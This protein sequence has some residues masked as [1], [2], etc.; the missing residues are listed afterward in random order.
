M[1]LSHARHQ[2]L[3]KYLESKLKKSG[4]LVLLPAI[5][6]RFE[7]L[8]LADPT[9]TG[10]YCKWILE[11][12]LKKDIALPEDTQKLQE[13]LTVYHRVKRRLPLEFREI[14]RFNTYSQLRITLLPMLPTLRSN[15]ELIREGSE[16]IATIPIKDVLY[17]LFKLTTPEAAS[18][19]AKNTGW[20]ICNL[21]TAADYL[22]RSPLYLITRNDKPYCLAHRD[23]HQV[24]D[25]NDQPFFPGTENQ[26]YQAILQIFRQYLPEFLCQKPRKDAPLFPHLQIVNLECSSHRCQ[27]IGCPE[28][29]FKQC[30]FKDCDD[31]F[32]PKH[33]ETCADCDLSFCDSHSYECASKGCS[34][35]HCG[36]DRQTCR[37]CD[38]TICGECSHHCEECDTLYCDEC[39]FECAGSNCDTICRDCANSSECEE[40][41]GDYCAKCQEKGMVCYNCNA[42]ICEDCLQQHCDACAGYLCPRCK[43]ECPSCK[44][45]FCHDCSWYCRKHCDETY[46]EECYRRICDVCSKHSK[47]EL[48][49][50]SIC[51]K[52][53]ICPQCVWKCS[54][55]GENI[56]GME[57]QKCN[58]PEEHILCS[59][60][61]QTQ[62]CNCGFVVCNPE[63][64]YYCAYQRS[65][66]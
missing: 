23:S 46:C 25:Q 60:C 15:A 58:C 7:Y 18:E 3:K 34:N 48:V 12:F 33:W 43:I 50:C 56:C 59:A 21:S 64:H 20:C 2:W 26:D 11:L 61:V 36:Q 30:E 44:G 9:L 52:E 63:D 6:D 17:Q 37:R 39:T 5:L 66:R 62:R 19:A 47:D 57:S 49:E 24:M 10:D 53:E 55:C 8:G 13:L 51:E 29:D 1:P 41:E 54:R 42:F 32:C 4:Q 38:E 31:W 16:L 45:S 40:C 14:T 35:I 28:C 27:E 22:E 65:W